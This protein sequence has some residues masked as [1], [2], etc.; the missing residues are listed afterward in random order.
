MLAS[1][2][3]VQCAQSCLPTTGLLSKRGSFSEPYSS[4][5]KDGPSTLSP[6]SFSILPKGRKKHEKDGLGPQEN[7]LATLQPWKEVGRRMTKT[8]YHGRNTCNDSS[9]RHRSRKR[10][11]LN[12]NSIELSLLSSHIVPSYQQGSSIKT[13][14]HS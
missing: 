3:L 2:I 6:F 12:Q 14:D 7:R 11:R 10:M 9:P 13:M 1:V 8:L 4:L 5:G